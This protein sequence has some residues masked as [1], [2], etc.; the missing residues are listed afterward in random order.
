[1][2]H[3]EFYICDVDDLVNDATQACLLKNPLKDLNGNS[4]FK[5]NI[6]QG[7]IVTSLILP[8]ELTC[9]HC[10]LQVNKFK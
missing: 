8:P 3:S 1:M 10:V 2:G 7:P 9:N 6:I 4:K 5:V